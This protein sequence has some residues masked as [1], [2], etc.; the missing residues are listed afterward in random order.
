MRL[1][2]PRMPRFIRKHAALFALAAALII[3]LGTAADAFARK[4]NGTFYLKDISGS[5][6]ALNG[7]SI[8]G[9]LSDGYQRTAFAIRD[10]RLTSNTHLNEQ[11]KRVQPFMEF[12]TGGNRIP[13]WIYMAQ[14]DSNQ[15]AISSYTANELT[16]LW[17]I[18]GKTS[19]NPQLE[20]PTK[21]KPVFTN[22]LPYGIAKIGDKVFFTPPVIAGT[23]GTG[24]IYE[25]TFYDWVLEM[26]NKLANYKAVPV[27]EYSLEPEE[28]SE[29]NGIDVLGLEAVGDKLVLLSAE[30]ETLR[31]RSFDSASGSLLGEARL[32]DFRLNQMASDGDSYK[33]AY[34]A[35]S[36]DG[37]NRLYLRFPGGP[38]LLLSVNLSNG[39]ELEN[40][41]RLN[42][43][44]SEEE[45]YNS[46]TYMRERNG[47]LYVFRTTREQTDEKDLPNRLTFPWHGYVYAYD[48]SALLYQGELV[49]DI[50]D[51]LLEL[52]NRTDNGGFPDD[53]VRYRNFRKI[54]I[55]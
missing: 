30:N 3:I 11:P 43:E 16:G 31:I 35:E 47:K 50:N 45:D 39:V 15:I 48:D 4:D 2:L 53:S 7:V 36:V 44:D 37:E 42:L 52:L 14:I 46:L 8:G 5:R 49:T 13:G 27:V 25:L 26:Q 23:K 34:K 12:W 55:P 40:V 17:L 6:E 10:G 18:S 21:N 41:A 33:P 32:P 29:A 1:R 20:Y 24:T 28:P 38:Q 54:S 22:E 51:D 9:E 19:V